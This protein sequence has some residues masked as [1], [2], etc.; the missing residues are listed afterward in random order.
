LETADEAFC[1]VLTTDD[2]GWTT[3]T[4]LYVYDNCAWTVI[5]ETRNFETNGEALV[6]FITSG[7]I[8]PA[9]VPVLEAGPQLVEFNGIQLE[10]DVSYKEVFRDEE[11]VFLSHE[12]EVYIFTGAVSE[13]DGTFANASQW[14]QAEYESYVALWDHIKRFNINGVD[15]LLLWDDAEGAAST[16]YG[17]YMVGDHWWMIQVNNASGPDKDEMLA[18]TGGGVLTVK[19][20]P[21]F[22]QTPLAS[23]DR[24]T[25]TDQL[26]AEYLGLQISYSPD[27]TVDDTWSPTGDYTHET[28]DMYTYRYKL[29]E[30]GATDA[31]SFAWVLA[32]E[33]CAMW[34]SYEVGLAG[35]IPYVLMRDEDSDYFLVIGTYANEDSCWE[36][37]I[38]CY[39]S[40]LLDQAIWYATA[41]QILEGASAT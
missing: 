12:M 2:D 35:G 20:D 39:D 29:E 25:M 18:I 1:Y 26:T 37:D 32:E 8:E 34:D 13:L 3:L 23:R 17:Y 40:E 10:L 15:C 9:E 14:A 11:Y 33:W 24:I 16:A 30:Q 41:G 5:G 28:M 4:G 27:W 38:H 22:E 21:P 36:I 6:R 7:R 31:I 19:E